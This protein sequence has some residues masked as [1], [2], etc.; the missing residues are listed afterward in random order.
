[1]R[2]PNRI[3]F[4]A[5]MESRSISELGA[6]IKILEELVE[7]DKLKSYIESNEVL[8]KLHKYIKS[9]E[10]C[11]CFCLNQIVKILRYDQKFLDFKQDRLFIRAYEGEVPRK[12]F[13]D[14]TELCLFAKNI[15]G[16]IDKIFKTETYGKLKD[17][18]PKIKKY[19]IESFYQI[20]HNDF[21]LLEKFETQNKDSV[22]LNLSR[23]YFHLKFHDAS[24]INIA[25][26]DIVKKGR[27]LTKRHEDFI[28]KFDDSTDKNDE[29]L[30]QEY[31]SLEDIKDLFVFLH[32]NENE[33]RAGSLPES[34]GDQQFFNGFKAVIGYLWNNLFDD[35]FKKYN[36]LSEVIL[37]KNWAEFDAYFEKIKD[38]IILPLE[39][40]NEAV[41]GFSDIIFKK[42]QII[43]NETFEEL[44]NEILFPEY[45]E[46]LTVNDKLDQK[47]LWYP[48]N[49]IKSLYSIPCSNNFILVLSGLLNFEN[50]PILVIRFIHPQGYGNNF[51]YA[52]LAEGPLYNLFQDAADWYL[53]FDFATNHSGTGS[54]AWRMVEEFLNN[55]RSKINLSECRIN[56]KKFRE[57]IK[58]KEIKDLSK[59]I[60]KLEDYYAAAKGMIY[61]LINAYI[62]SKLGYQ[63]HW[64][65][66][67]PSITD[68]KE[69]DLLAYRKS[70]KMI[71]FYVIETSTTG[72]NLTKEVK[73]KVKILKKNSSNLLKFLKLEEYINFKFRG[74]AISNIKPDPQDDKA[75]KQ[76][77]FKDMIKNLQNL[78]MDIRRLNKI[79]DS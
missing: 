39:K 18:I 30:K 77:N 57:Y 50:Y 20:I 38:D 26:F 8:N 76:I 40:R 62:L 36:F 22:I 16:L 6:L 3:D 10:F 61:E 55:H 65:L 28:E 56:S 25:Y 70:G 17:I 31:N 44:K 9:Y 66:K 27:V 54:R 71:M 59:K 35:A 7:F 49:V 64:A 78:R 2:D 46:D 74:M 69:I 29:Y 19:I 21:E 72:E 79:I 4:P 75:V 1:M 51:S 33:R 42:T 68:G 34:L 41:D 5:I 53:Y 43:Y 60:K 24:S 11:I 13:P 52:I 15:F 14:C 47:F 63:V 45:S 58:N 67:E 73:Q 48:V 23:S 37:S 32:A 12:K